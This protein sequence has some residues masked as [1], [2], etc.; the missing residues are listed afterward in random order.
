[1]EV[2]QISISFDRV[3]DVYDQTRSLPSETMRKL[4]KTLANE[5]SGCNKILDVGMGTG[6]FSKPL[7]DVGFEV[8]GVDIS[9]KMISKAREKGVNSMLLSD[10]C[11]LPFKGN[12]FDASICV[13]VLHLISHWKTALLEACRVTNNFMVSLFYAAKDPVREAYY[14]LMKNYGYARHWPG[15]EGDLK[16]IVSPAKSVFACSYKMFADDRLA[17]FAQ[18]ASSSQWQIPENLNRKVVQELRSQFAGKVFTQQLYV[19]MWKIDD[20]KIF[21]NMR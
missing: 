21:C 4:V 19:L 11:S 8:V 14:A 17:N 13:H 12:A 6:R 18:R 10:A 9:R 3:A 16:D 2:S 5:L 20:L 15:A 7:Q 1:V